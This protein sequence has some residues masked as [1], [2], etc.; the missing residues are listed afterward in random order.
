MREPIHESEPRKP[1]ARVQVTAAPAVPSPA[2]ERGGDLGS[3]H[4][5]SHH[6]RRR[7]PASARAGLDAR[8]PAL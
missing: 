5:A 4:V 7:H 6:H 8:S 2:F 3:A 1:T